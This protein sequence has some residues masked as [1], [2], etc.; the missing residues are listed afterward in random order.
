MYA[1]DAWARSK[2]VHADLSACVPVALTPTTVLKLPEAR[3]R[4]PACYA[5]TVLPDSS[6]HVN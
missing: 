4:D 1:R 5:G 2:T 6:T 3:L